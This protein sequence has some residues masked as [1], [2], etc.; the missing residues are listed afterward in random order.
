MADDII[1]FAPGGKVTAEETNEN[2]LLLKEWAL[3]NSQSEAYIDNKI[4]ALTN[5]LNGQ[6]SSL[7]TQVAACVK[8]SGNQTVNGAKYFQP[9]ANV[10][11]PITTQAI[12]KNANGCL[13]MGNGIIIQWGEVAHVDNGDV[14]KTTVTF[15]TPFTNGGTYQAVASW[16][17]MPKVGDKG[18]CWAITNQSST[19]MVIWHETASSQ[20]QSG[21]VYWIAIGY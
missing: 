13:K 2:N 6:I 5:T 7:N 18:F 11:T 16:T 12:T 9:L 19:N 3:D 8:T 21:T 10:N 14:Q 4:T 1:Q 20:H 15:R 17:M